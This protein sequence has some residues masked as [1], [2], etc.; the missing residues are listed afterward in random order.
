MP[1]LFTPQHFNSQP[2]EGFY[3]LIRSFTSTY[4]TV[5]NC[6]VKEILGRIHKI[7]LQSSIS[8]TKTQIIYPTRSDNSLLNHFDLPTE[9]EILQEIEKCSINAMEDAVSLGLLQ[10]NKN[11]S[12]IECAVPPYKLP[13]NKQKL[14][15]MFNDDEFIEE[16]MLCLRSTT[17]KNFAN[18]FDEN[19]VDISSP[20]VDIPNED[21]R[22]II[23]KTS[24]CWLLRKTTP[25]LS[26]DRLERVKFNGGI[27]K[28]C[29]KKRVYE[30]FK[31]KHHYIAMR[32]Y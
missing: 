15:H 31:L 26:S 1:H 4:S 27:I 30:S 24:L 20:F 22:V 29:S 9:S 11:Q 32:K 14:Q 2:C 6:S 21:R 19:G 25:K 8:N 28:K 10:K 13:K 7:Q 5:A 16:I 3:R 18:K 23:K 12:Q 17:L